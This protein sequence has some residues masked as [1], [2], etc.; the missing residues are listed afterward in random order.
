M[1]GMHE[2]ARARAGRTSTGVRRCV[3]VCV[4]TSLLAACS[5]PAP[6]APTSAPPAPA[7]T[8]KPAAQVSPGVAASPSASP[9]G[10][11]APSPAA[12]PAPSPSAALAAS[13]AAAA[14]PSAAAAPVAAAPPGGAP[15]KI[16]VVTPLSPPGDPSAGQL[17]LR[18]AQLGADYL[19]QR[20][21]GLISATCPLP[22][23]IELVQADDSGTP[24]KGVAA[25]RKVVQND[26]VVGVVGQFHSSVTLAIAPIADQLKVPLFSTQSSDVKITAEH[27]AFV[28]QTHTITSDR[29]S[30]VADFIKSSGFKKIAMVAESTDYGTGNVESL[31]QALQGAAGIQTQDWTFDNKATDISPLLLQVKA[32][33]P[34]LIYNLGVGAPAY[35][36]VKQ[37]YEAG[38]MPATPMLLSYDLPIRPEFWQNLGEQ[39][40]GIIFVVYYHPQE[41]LTDAGAWMQQRYQQEFNEPALYTS[42]AA[43]GNVL[44]IAEAVNQACSTDGSALARTLET[45]KFTTWNLTG[46]S[47]PPAEGVDYHRIVQP[48]LMLQYLQTNQDYAK[49]S[50]VYPPNMKT[51]DVQKSP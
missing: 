4:L 1:D 2:T 39:G 20:Q 40:K 47:F 26:G 5:P 42:F 18:G 44:E 28:F 45:G 36:M 51:A 25:F 16:G 49:A 10:G 21:G 29:A 46:V 37:S 34:D 11:A 43:F 30:A 15:T 13:P 8:T 33:G 17:I 7:P 3:V 14:S 12:S 6:A 38:L 41:K 19:N 31:K 22:G 27:H 9:S 35:L 50:I 23:P 32:F 24:E 48:L